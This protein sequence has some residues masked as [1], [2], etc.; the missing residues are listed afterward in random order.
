MRVSIAHAVAVF[1]AWAML[2]A[3][4]GAEE[5][6]AAESRVGRAT[7]F[8]RSLGYDPRCYQAKVDERAPSL[9]GPDKRFNIPNVVFVPTDA[10]PASYPLRVFEQGSAGADWDFELQAPTTFQRSVLR[11]AHEVA[12]AEWPDTP[13]ISSTTFLVTEVP[14]RFYVCILDTELIERIKTGKW[15]VADGDR[16]VVLKRADLSVVDRHE[17][18]N[19]PGASGNGS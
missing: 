17:N 6:D 5:P 11:R 3:A 16:V 4:F 14:H 13:P 18:C 8:V 2:T 1:V 12:S 15:L 19:A 10:C 7:D 9:L